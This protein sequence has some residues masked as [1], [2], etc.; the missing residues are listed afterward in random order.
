MCLIC[1]TLTSTVA[2]NGSLSTAVVFGGIP[3]IN[4]F[5]YATLRLHLDASVFVLTEISPVSALN[6]S[7]IISL[8][9]LP[10]TIIFTLM[11]QKYINVKVFY[12]F[13]NII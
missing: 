1:N 5:A 4:L 3:V 10:S 11:V 12:Q 2:V 8:R 7:Q 6:V 13:L 9:F